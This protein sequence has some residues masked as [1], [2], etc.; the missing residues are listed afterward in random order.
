MLIPLHAYTRRPS[1][2]QFGYFSRCLEA[3]C[4]TR[5]IPLDSDSEAMVKL[6]DTLEE[7]ELKAMCTVQ[8]ADG[9]FSAVGG[10]CEAFGI[11]PSPAHV[12]P[13]S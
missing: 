8:S 4:G 9:W 6:A 5:G 12:P 11:T 2:T 10:L 7:D 3:E 1:P 13:C